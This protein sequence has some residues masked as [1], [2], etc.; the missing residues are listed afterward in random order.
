MLARVTSLRFWLV[1]AMLVA[2]AI[3]LAG[4]YLAYGRIQSSQERRADR[5]KAAL[6]A[7]AVAAQAAAGA[8][9]PRFAA[10]QAVL[11]NNQVIVIRDGKRVFTGPAIKDRDLEVT[12]GASFP[13][14]RVLVRD[15]ES[16][17]QSSSLWL[18]LVAAGVI[19]IVILAA[20]LVATLLTRAVRG[21]VERAVAAADRLAAG[22]LSARMGT[23][24]PDELV[25]LG[26]AFDSMAERLEA[27]DQE[28]RRFLADIAHEIA[29]PTTAI[30]GYGLALADGSLQTEA[31]RKEAQSLI[32]SETRR[33]GG[34]IE[35]LRELTRLDLAEE[36]RRA[37]V[38]LGE[39]C[40]GVA[41]RF[42][43][44]ES[45]AGVRLEVDARRVVIES[46]RR[47]LE[48]ILDNLVS[49]AI[50]YTPT[51]GRVNLQLRH[52]RGEV[53]VAVRDTGI[54]IPPEQQRRVFDRLY[55]VDQARDRVRGG[56]GL[57][58]A[59]AQRA[60][61]ALGGRIE[62]ESEP[63]RGSE[64]RLV[65]PLAGRRLRSRAAATPAPRR[66]E[67]AD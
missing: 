38:D 59:I 63:G 19:V 23:S 22:D 65:L 42:A 50:R 17:G 26:R 2:G 62:L 33:L 20:W 21:P 9:Y 61:H 29:T 44:A 57:G 46:D 52:G 30:S 66:A 10:L 39:V 47:L 4:A 32:E 12:V 34:L 55:R 54:G 45:T 67:A 37:R 16:D 48:M 40:R 41:S 1:V 6:Q 43:P 31:E 53:I 13:R 8:G 25:H 5:H 51:G 35:D 18:T 64:F 11:P 49:N 27:A 24:G 36:V 58:L 28:Q 56:S 3:G 15:Y 7:A 60:A 14:G